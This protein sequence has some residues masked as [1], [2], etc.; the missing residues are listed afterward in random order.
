V[1]L[2]VDVITAED[3]L[4]SSR[5]FFI[6]GT[7]VQIELAQAFTTPLPCYPCLDLGNGRSITFNQSKHVYLTL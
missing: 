1:D 2:L 4:S 6:T 3:R 5:L 7:S